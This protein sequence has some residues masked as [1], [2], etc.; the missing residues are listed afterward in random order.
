MAETSSH[1]AKSPALR[2][3]GN[4]NRTAVVRPAVLIVSMAAEV[5]V[6]GVMV[7]EGV[8]QLAPEGRPAVQDNVTV[9]LKLF[10]PVTM[11]G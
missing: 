11:S 1:A 8:V 9:P 4:R 5:V 3:S 6:L 2:P 7:A 10:F